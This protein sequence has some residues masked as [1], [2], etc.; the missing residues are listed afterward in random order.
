MSADGLSWGAVDP[1]DGVRRVLVIE[2]DRDS[3]KT[4]RGSLA[5][6]GFAVTTLSHGEDA[7]AAV[8]RERPHLVMLDWEYP[9]VGARLLKHLQ[10][11]APAR[12]TRLMALSLYSD[13]QQ[14]VAGFEFGVD[15]YIARPYS[16]PELL[17]RVRAVLRPSRVA[18]EDPDFIQVQRLRADL[19]DLRLLVDGQIVQLRPMEFRLLSYLMRYPERLFTRDQLL[20]RVWPFDSQ[21]DTRAVDVT[22]QRTRR[23][24]SQHGCGGYLQTVRAFGYRLSGCVP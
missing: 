22:V 13:E 21:A 9:G 24:L 16:L 2:R 23:A 4:L 7:V 3:E 12:R 11:E 20:A 6:A 10:R 8:E 1:N 18:A 19:R 14:I 15:D 5:Q 17:A